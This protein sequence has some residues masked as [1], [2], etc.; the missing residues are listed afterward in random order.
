[1]SSEQTEPAKLVVDE[2]HGSIVVT[3]TGE[4][5]AWLSNFN[6]DAPKA[7]V[8]ELREDLLEPLAWWRKQ[9][10]YYQSMSIRLTDEVNRLERKFVTASGSALILLVILACFIVHSLDLP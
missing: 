7:A 1:M 8:D 2:L 6:F 10:E 9:A 4:N 3:S 5:Q